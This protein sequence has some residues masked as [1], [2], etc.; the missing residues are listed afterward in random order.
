MESA[1]APPNRYVNISRKI[2]GIRT[3]SISCTGKCLNAIIARHRWVRVADTAVARAGRS[4]ADS[5]VRS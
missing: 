4:P 1:N 2:S 5:T 3:M